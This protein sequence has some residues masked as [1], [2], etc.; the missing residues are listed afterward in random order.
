MTILH[1]ILL[2]GTLGMVL[3]TLQLLDQIKED[4]KRRAELL[5]QTPTLLPPPLRT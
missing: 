2:M 4:V 5:K 1:P 3:A